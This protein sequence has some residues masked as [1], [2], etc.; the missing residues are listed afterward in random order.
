MPKGSRSPHGISVHLAPKTH[1]P[2]PPVVLR[3]V[4]CV[5]ILPFRLSQV[6]KKRVT[7]PTILLDTQPFAEGGSRTR[8]LL[9]VL[10]PEASASA[11]SATPA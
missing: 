9:L 8:T 1:V 6:N 3:K 5:F 7:Y 11:N 2:R 4:A 10:A